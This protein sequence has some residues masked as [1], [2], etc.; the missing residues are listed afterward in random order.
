MRRVESAE[1]Q[2]SPLKDDNGPVLVDDDTILKMP[3][4]RAGEN[5]S[6]DVAADRRE[7][8]NRVSM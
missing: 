4:N 5:G 3:A 7:L 2:K 6:L 8:V 1:S